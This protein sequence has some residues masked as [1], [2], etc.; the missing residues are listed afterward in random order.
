MNLFKAILGSWPSQVLIV[1]SIE[2]MYQ[3]PPYSGKFKQVK[4][5]YRCGGISF[6]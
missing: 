6:I 4:I 1:Q 3:I 5:I 2:G